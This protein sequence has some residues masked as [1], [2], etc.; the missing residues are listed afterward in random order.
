MLSVTSDGGTTIPLP[1]WTNAFD[2]SMT[3][4]VSATGSLDNAGHYYLIT[5]PVKYT[6]Y[7][8]VRMRATVSVSIINWGA[9]YSCDDAIASSGVNA[10]TYTLQAVVSAPATET[11]IVAVNVI[12]A[13]YL[14][15]NI[16]DQAAGSAGTYSLYDA[17]FYGI[18]NVYRNLGGI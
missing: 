8:L 6:G 7:F 2:A 15:V 5:L 10:N 16:V 1:L 18:T 13:K 14:R 17:S 12:N 4:M 11:N 3:T 9:G